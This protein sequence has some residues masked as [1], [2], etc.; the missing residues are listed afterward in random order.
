LNFKT[1]TREEFTVDNEQLT[2][3]KSQQPTDLS[4]LTKKELIALGAEIGLELDD[5]STKS[6]LIKAIE[7]V[8]N[9][10]L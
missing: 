10:K 8:S 2:D 9:L 5:K 1:V 3:K 6:D 7:E 4:A